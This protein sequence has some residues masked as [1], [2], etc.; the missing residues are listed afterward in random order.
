M[1]KVFKKRALAIGLTLIA[2][3]FLLSACGKDKKEGA[4]TDGELKGEITFWHSFTQGPRMESIQKSA[5]DF[6][7]EHPDVKI[8]IESFSWDDFYQK[9]TTGLASNNV[10]DMSTA[11][12]NHVVEMID[13]GA[14]VPLDDLIDSIGRER[15][16]EMSIGEG[17]VDGNDYSIPL[18]SHAQVMWIRKDLLEKNNLEVPETW[19][20]FA[21]AAEILTKDGVY[22]AS[23]PTGSNDFLGT[24]YL[25]Y[26]VRSH[27]ESLLTD[28]LK[29]NI[30]SEAAIEG[31][32]FWVDV[33]E[34][35]SPKDSITYN[36]L[37]QATL[38]YQGKTAFDFNSGFQIAG[39]EANSPDL[40]EFVDAAPIPKVNKDDE[41]LG[42]ET[43]NIPMVVW[44][45]SEHP[46]ICKAFIEYLFEKD[47]YIE[48]LS[49]TPVGMLPS[50]NDISEEPAYKQNE[51]IQQFSH[52][53]K[54]ISDAVAKGTA[55]G[56]EHGPS[57]QAGLL[58]SQGII[59]S[60]FQDIITNDVPVEKAAKAAEKELN[61]IFDSVSQ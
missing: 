33:Y 21:K 43:A 12:P 39:V 46:E 59:E 8:K 45:N 9:W 56:Y 52:A 10:P 58:V 11:L 27:G 55:I 31:I 28:D 42:I 15:F 23:F 3:L 19:E 38:Y 54:V 32:K 16:S 53:E 6:E 24:R 18:Y 4:A 36:V 13:S 7:K 49:A 47:R 57:V 17:H 35:A 14:I 2:S 26:Y 29:A 5:E 60:M 41:E 50:L 25:N 20:E 44:E 30:T 1:K 34:K 48:F 37:D 40:L 51:M 22:G 61:E